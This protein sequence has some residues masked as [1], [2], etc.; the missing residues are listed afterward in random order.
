MESLW[1]RGQPDGAF[2]AALMSFMWPCWVYTNTMYLVIKAMRLVGSTYKIYALVYWLYTYPQGGIFEDTAI[3]KLGLL[4]FLLTIFDQLAEV[5]LGSILALGHTDHFCDGG[6]LMVLKKVHTI[7][8]EA[9]F[10]ANGDEAYGVSD[11][12]FNLAVALWNCQRKVVYCDLIISVFVLIK[13]SS[14]FGVKVTF[15]LLL[16]TVVFTGVVTWLNFKLG[17]YQ[18]DIF[19]ATNEMG[20]LM[21]DLKT[22]HPALRLYGWVQNRTTKFRELLEKYRRGMLGM[23]FWQAVISG[24]GGQAEFLALFIIY[25]YVAMVAGRKVTVKDALIAQAY[26]G[27][28][29]QILGTIVFYFMSGTAEIN[30]RAGRIEKFLKLP[31]AKDLPQTGKRETSSSGTLEVEN[32]SYGYPVPWWEIVKAPHIPHP[33]RPIAS[34]VT[35]AI[36]PGELVLVVGPFE[37]QSVDYLPRAESGLILSLLGEIPCLAGRACL[38]EGPVV[39]Q[40][41]FFAGRLLEEGTVRENVLWGIPESEC[42]EEHLKTALVASQLGTDLNTPGSL[43]HAKGQYTKLDRSGSDLSTTQRGRLLLA[44]SIYGVLEGAKLALIDVAKEDE[45]IVAAA[46]DAAVLKAMKG[47]TRVVLTVSPAQL[48][49]LAPTADR[50]LLFSRA[51][52]GPA[53]LLYNGPPAQ[54][55]E[56]ALVEA[57]GSTVQLDKPWQE[58]PKT[59]PLIDPPETLAA[60]VPGAGKMAGTGKKPSKKQKEAD[61]ESAAMDLAE[62]VRGHEALMEFVGVGKK[63]TGAQQ[64]AE[65]VGEE[66]AA[67]AAPL[68]LKREDWEKF[69]RALRRVEET[70]QDLEAEKDGGSSYMSIIWKLSRRKRRRLL[71]TRLCQELQVLKE[72]LVWA[73]LAAWSTVDPRSMSGRAGDPFYLKVIAAL[74]IGFFSLVCASQCWHDSLYMSIQN[75]LALQRVDVLESIGMRFFWRKRAIADDEMKALADT[76]NNELSM[77]VQ[78]PF[79]VIVRFFNFLLVARHAPSLWLVLVLDIVSFKLIASECEWRNKQLVPSEDEVRRR[80]C[81]TTAAQMD[82]AVPRRAFKRTPCFEKAQEGMLN[83]R[84]AFNVLD[85]GHQVLHMSRSIFRKGIY[86]LYAL[87]IASRLRNVGVHWTIAAGFFVLTASLSDRILDTGNWFGLLSDYLEI[88]RKFRKFEA[89][90]NMDKE[91]LDTKDSSTDLPENWPSKGAVEFENVSFSAVPSGRAQLRSLSFKVNGGEKVGIVGKDGCGKSAL[92]NVLLRLGP[93]QGVGGRVLIDGVDLETVKLE[94]LRR[95]VGVVPADP[96]IFAGDL[97]RNI[98]EEFAD[99]EVLVALD[100]CG[101][102]AKKLTEMQSLAGTLSTPI[103]MDKVTP[104][105]LHL[106]MLARAIVRKPKVMIADVCTASLDEDAAARVVKLVKERSKKG[107]VLCVVNRCC[108]VLQWDRIMEL[109]SGQLVALDTPAKLLEDAGGFFATQ[110]RLEGVQPAVAG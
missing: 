42:H 75:T 8:L 40:P 63:G 74:S 6:Q 84:A 29:V 33:P 19:G 15:L 37:D 103:R 12:C 78:I 18:G 31:E 80:S 10:Q 98:G 36:P 101:V 1:N 65:E 72:P 20:G 58:P 67:P 53:K 9:L 27:T 106:L 44:R 13:L 3:W 93:L 39:L 51:D 86:T 49:L 7:G 81:R 21:D 77:L 4:F 26:T 46:W 68:E 105:Q 90:V 69:R 61:A 50:L 89:F 30:W 14:L 35:F 107:T 110:C 17:P 83:V 59:A 38:P 104:E 23:Q 96:V 41:P 91:F 109:S 48:E 52:K 32:F 55:D 71:M 102:D 70:A 2:A 92:V 66:G 47:A 45:A 108:D 95:Q 100:A 79:Q 85:F 22:K 34:D 97:K 62:M 60:K 43:L 64:E 99:S 57:L 54:A 25:Y 82:D 88:V 73:T 16:S 5:W 11:E 76:D 24:V 56:K 28:L 87:I 94:H